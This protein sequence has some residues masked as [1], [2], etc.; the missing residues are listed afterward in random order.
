MTTVQRARGAA[1]ARAALAGNPSDGYGGA[2]LAVTLPAWSA[3]AEALPAAE[4]E[5]DPPNVLVE[6]T[7]RRFARELEPAGLATCI[8]WSTT[9]PQQVGLGSSSALV[10]AVIRALCD[11]HGA[12]LRSDELAE[13]AL[14]VESEDLGIVAGLQDRVAQAYEGLTFMDFREASTGRGGSYEALDPGLLP[15]L[16]IAWRPEAAG[17]SGQIHSSLHARHRDGEPLVHETMDALAQ[18][19]RD[20]RDALRG[21]D[22]ERFCGCVDRTF[23]LRRRVVE[24]DPLCVEMVEAARNCGASANYTGS[25]GAIVAACSDPDA[26][27]AVAVALDGI[28]CGVI[29]A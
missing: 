13:L 15:P 21:G 6:A 2:V 3:R 7:V 22:L 14:A 10:I 16:L 28:G 25:G 27:D 4:L 9:I 17:H 26:L 1:L 23:D 24:L 18:A 5:C 12:E 19:A 11:L 29:R 20:A 8:R